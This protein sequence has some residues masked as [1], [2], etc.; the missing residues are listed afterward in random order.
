[1]GLVHRGWDLNKDETTMPARLSDEGYSTHLFG[2]QHEAES[3]H[4]L[5]YEYIHGDEQHPRALDVANQ[6]QENIK[7]I[8]SD[9][10]FFAG[11]GFMET[12]RTAPDMNGEFGWYDDE[13]YGSVPPNEVSLPEFLP[14]N[15]VL[16]EQFAALQG[17]LRAVD[18][19]IRQILES[20]EEAGIHQNTV[21][22]FTADHGVPFPFAKTTLFDAGIETPLIIRYPN[23]FENGRVF[24]EMVSNIDLFPTILDLIGAEILPAIDGRSLLPLLNG[25]EYIPRDRIFAEQTFHVSPG[26]S[27]AIR[28][29]RFKYIRNYLPNVDRP[30]RSDGGVNRDEWP[31][32]ELYDLREDP[33]ELTNVASAET[34]H[35]VLSTLRRELYDWM[36]NTNDPIVEGRI[37][38]PTRE[39]PDRVTNSP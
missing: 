9:E 20:L 35:G 3:P 22:I 12:H 6:F 17:D 2:F 7:D 37:P 19:A 38:L 29:N 14:E 18:D 13:K 25:E 10:P 32:E 24:E 36:D 23:G 34:Y 31:E 39:R 4:S 26:V 30:M 33:N 27:R 15:S 11:L 5:G 28:T 1:M 21:V 8:I 16:R